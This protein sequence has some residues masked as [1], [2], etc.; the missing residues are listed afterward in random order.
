METAVKWLY[1]M[2]SSVSKSD[3]RHPVKGNL[4]RTNILPYGFLHIYCFQDAET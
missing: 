2:R 1:R 3:N 4:T